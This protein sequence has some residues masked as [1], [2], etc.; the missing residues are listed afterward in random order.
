MGIRRILRIGQ[1]L[2]VT[3]PARELHELG[4]KEGA[5]VEVEVDR[6]QRR[7]VIRP[8]DSATGVD[9]SFVEEARRFA[10]RHRVILEELARR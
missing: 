10:E 1:S 2:G 5:P 8:L 6:V 4:L 3:L 7:V 9:P